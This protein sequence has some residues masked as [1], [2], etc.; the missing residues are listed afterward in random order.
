MKTEVK[1]LEFALKGG[2][3]LEILFHY[4]DG[5]LFEVVKT[6]YPD[7]SYIYTANGGFYLASLDGSVNHKNIPI[8]LVM[9][10]WK[11]YDKNGRRCTDTKLYWAHN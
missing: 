3:K 5:R 2:I 10:W 6:A 4:E 8:D 11:G 9:D 7:K 1:K